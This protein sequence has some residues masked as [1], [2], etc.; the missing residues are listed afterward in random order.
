MVSFV[1][2]IV[3][4]QQT[5]EGVEDSA[6]LEVVEDSEVLLQDLRNSTMIQLLIFQLNAAVKGAIEDGLD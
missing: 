5:S 4:D 3:E 1:A 2:F 6:F